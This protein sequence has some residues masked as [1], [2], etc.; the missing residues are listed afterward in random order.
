MIQEL[1]C[2]CGMPKCLFGS[3]SLAKLWDGMG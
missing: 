3:T 1:A 2:L